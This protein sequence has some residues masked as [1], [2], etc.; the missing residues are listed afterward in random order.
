[1]MAGI[2]IASGCRAGITDRK[3]SSHDTEETIFSKSHLAGTGPALCVP[4][5]GPRTKRRLTGAT[6]SLR[7]KVPETLELVI[8]RNKK[9]SRWVPGGLP[10]GSAVRR[11]LRWPLESPWGP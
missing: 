6:E 2:R 9:P 1:M 3:K 7:T 4:A 8:S 10:N 11:E 5:K